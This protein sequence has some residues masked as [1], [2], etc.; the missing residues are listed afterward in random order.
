[1]K[2]AY[3]IMMSVLGFIQIAEGSGSQKSASTPKTVF[4]CQESACNPY[5]EGPQC[6][7]HCECAYYEE[8]GQYLGVCTTADGVDGGD[9]QPYSSGVNPNVA[10]QS[11][12]ALAGSVVETLAVARPKLS[13]LKKLKTPFQKMKLSIRKIKPN[14]SIRKPKIRFGRRG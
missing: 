3:C 6:G 7:P 5:N 8:D 12:T 1:M 13:P 14:L 2:I 10:V 11:G 9:Y 4:T